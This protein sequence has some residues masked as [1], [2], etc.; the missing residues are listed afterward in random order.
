MNKEE[1]FGKQRFGD[2]NERGYI[3]LVRLSKAPR[4]NINSTPRGHPATGYDIRI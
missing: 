4:W 3:K 2:W 1:Y